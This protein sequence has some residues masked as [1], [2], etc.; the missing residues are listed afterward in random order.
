M[1]LNR[2]ALM[3]Y[4]FMIPVIEA[5]K[6]GGHY[7]CIC[8]ADEPEVEQLRNR[9]IDVFTHGL[10]RSLTPLNILKAILR[11]RRI[12][13]DQQIDVLICHS[14]FGAGVGRLAARLAKTRHA[15][16]FAHGLPCAPAQYPLIWLLWFGIEKFLALFTDAF[17]VM[18][19]YDENLA[20]KHLAKNQGSVFRISG[21]GVDLTKFNP[22]GT[23][24][25]KRQIYEEL[26]IRLDRKIVLCTALLKPTK[27]VF[28]FLEAARRICARRSDVC[29]LLAGDGPEMGKLKDLCGKYNLE[30]SFK[31][32]GWRD[33]VDG[34]LRATD[35]FVLPSFYFEGLPVSILEAMGCG[36]PVVSTR[37]RGCEDAVVHEDT[38]FLVPVKQVAPLADK[39]SILLDNPQ[40]CRDMGRAGRQRAEKYFELNHCTEKIVEAIEIACRQN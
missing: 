11:T 36:K 6:K 3:F 17:L 32:L 10:K 26:N 34:L 35:I 8:T 39:I 14:P 16:Y 18:N 4:K 40:L 25:D 21:V 2:A 28:V 5:Q 38:G 9:G 7:V 33:D 37:H 22:T 30:G 13:V 31:M 23:K 12:L 29:F 15:I 1:H 19:N 20:I 27:G 24:R